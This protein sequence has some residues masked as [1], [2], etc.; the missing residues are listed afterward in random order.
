MIDPCCFY[1]GSC[2]VV[3]LLVVAVLVYL[4]ADRGLGP[5]KGES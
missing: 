2:I 3:L 5:K 4:I 1:L